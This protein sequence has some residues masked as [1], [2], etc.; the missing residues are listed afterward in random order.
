MVNMVL[1]WNAIRPLNGSRA[2]GFEEL[3]T[4]LARAGKP[5]DAHFERKGT[6]DAGVECY[7]VLRDRTEWAWQSKYFDKG[8]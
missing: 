4:Q 5:A 3:C 6:P 8:A 7:A 2:D 1:D